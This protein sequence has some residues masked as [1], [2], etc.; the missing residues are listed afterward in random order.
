MAVVDIPYWDYYP[1]GVVIFKSWNSLGLFY[2]VSAYL[3][4]IFASV[5]VGLRLY[6]RTILTR[7]FGYDDGMSALSHATPVQCHG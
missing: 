3:T 7:F 1:P 4:L 2:V 6:T 5:F